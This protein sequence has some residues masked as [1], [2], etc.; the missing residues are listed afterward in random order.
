M[1]TSLAKVE[2]NLVARY[3]LEPWHLE[4][5]KYVCKPKA[6]R[7][8]RHFIMG[9]LGIGE[10]TY[11]YWL[12]HPKFNEARKEF[13]KQYYKDDVPDVLNAMKDEAIAGNPQAAKLFL[14]YVED[15]DKDPRN[16]DPGG[17]SPIPIMEVKQIIIN[18]QQKF[19]GR[20]TQQQSGG[21]EGEAKPVV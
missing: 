18:L 14:E 13:V 10:G 9:K 17:N 20:T 7:P 5:L 21:I 11:Y 6:L 1:I 19:Y 8:N 12:N 3:E 2:Q 15:F 4:L 16:F